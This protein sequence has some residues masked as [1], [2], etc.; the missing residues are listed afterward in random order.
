MNTL[1]APRNDQ[2][3]IMAEPVEG[4][5]SQGS[6]IKVHKLLSALRRFWWVPI[7]TLVIGLGVAAVMIKLAPPTF[8]SKARM[9]EQVKLRLPEG[10]LFY[11]DGQ[12]ALGTQNELL[13]S[14]RLRE[15]AL[16]HMRS[17]SNQVAIPRDETGAPIVVPIRVSQSAKS[18]VFTIETSGSNPAYIRAYL[19]ALTTVYP[20]YKKSVRRLVSGE[21]LANLTEQ[22]QRHERDLKLEQ[23]AL[24]AFQRSNNLVV[25]QQESSVAGTYL[26][27]LKTKLSEFELEDRL[28]ALSAMGA[29]A[30]N[31]ATTNQLESTLAAVGVSAGE[32]AGDDRLAAFKELHVLR[33]Q[34]DRLAKYLKDKHPKMVRLNSEIRRGEELLSMYKDQSR[35]QIAAARQTLRLKMENVQQAVTEWQLKVVQAN[36]QLA[37]AE[38][39]KLNV[40]RVQQVYDRLAKMVENLGISRNL[41][42]ETLAVLDPASEPERSYSREISMAG[43]GGMAG[44][45]VG[46]GLILLVALKDDR[47][48]SAR[49]VIEKFGNGVVGQVPEV[50]F[51][52]EKRLMLCDG[53]EQHMYAESYRNIRSAL[54][55]LAIEGAKP[56][57]ILVTSALPDEGKSTVAANLAHTLAMGGARVLL[58]DGDLRKGALHQLVG[59]NAS[60]GFTELLRRSATLDETLQANS[61]PNLRFIAAGKRITNA[62]DL[63]ISRELDDLLR[64]WREQYDHVI[65]DSTPIFA[66]DDAVTLAPKADGTLLVV[67]NRFSRAGQVREALELLMQRQAKILGM[68]FNR[69][70]PKSRA[71][72][73]YKYKEYYASPEVSS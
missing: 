57:I 54:L 66:A 42:Q 49:E 37:E 47:F 48:G 12:T 67:R 10:D 21:S 3:Y 24:L 40:Q 64:A 31:G 26:A 30:T 52:G 32:K 28:L 8:V 43:M 55:Y 25:L 59:L 41:D 14:G 51:N 72:Y 5:A 56:K 18:A 33:L 69:A 20:E 53:E 34:R 36:S 35:A 44:L 13:Q 6:P 7:V 17:S 39:L 60:P 70:N 58:V 73:Y 22:V 2:D 29:A 11:E 65:I 4:Q 46:L 62:G 63:F 50:T 71:Y 1:P 23:D 15:L 27:T 19:N 45:G 9:W 38:R 68:V 61:L 16:E